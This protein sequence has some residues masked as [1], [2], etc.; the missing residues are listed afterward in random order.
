MAVA[1]AA[2][3]ARPRLL[4]EVLGPPADGFVA[5]HPAEGRTRRWP[6]P[7]AREVGLGFGRAAGGQRR[8]RRRQ[9][10]CCSP[11]VRRKPRVSPT[12]CQLRPGRACRGSD[13]DRRRSPATAVGSRNAPASPLPGGVRTGP[14][15]GRRGSGGGAWAGSETDCCW[16]SDAEDHTGGEIPTRSRRHAPRTSRPRRRSSQGPTTPPSRWRHTTG[17]GRSS[18]APEVV[19]GASIRA[20]RRP[21]SCTATGCR[22]ISRSF[23][24]QVSQRGGGA[25]YPRCRAFSKIKGNCMSKERNAL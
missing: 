6:A 22:T 9:A 16:R 18:A 14:A 25:L 11:G 2:A 23:K 17:C 13:A 8:A 15:R 4:A 10:R 1:V 19:M 21:S 3:K 5:A 20:W 12:S 24:H 7:R